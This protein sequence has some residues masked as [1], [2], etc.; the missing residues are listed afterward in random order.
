MK[1]VLDFVKVEEKETI[2]GGR[3]G[4]VRLF[5][6]KTK[7]GTVDSVEA[8]TSSVGGDPRVVRRAVRLERPQQLCHVDP[9]S[10]VIV[11][12]APHGLKRMRQ[13]GVRGSAGTR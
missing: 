9:T 13:R 3:S 12:I 11:I 2:E 4:G 6:V 1:G 8:A 10:F 7:R 5:K